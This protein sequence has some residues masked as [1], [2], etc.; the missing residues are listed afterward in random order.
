[1]IRAVECVGVLAA[2]LAACGCGAKENA[3]AVKLPSTARQPSIT[4]RSQR[5]K[6]TSRRLPTDHSI[7]FRSKTESST[8]RPRRAT[9]ASK[10]S[11]FREGKAPA[12]AVAMYGD[13][14]A[15]MGF[16]RENY[17]PAK[18]NTE[19]K[20]TADVKTGGPNEFKFD[21]TSK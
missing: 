4:S 2:C 14:A 12:G 10:I 3:S 9:A 11:A 8:A 5:G 18:Y 21:L 13:K 19:S 20:L 15:Q 16:A 6:S 7:L 1:M 17:V